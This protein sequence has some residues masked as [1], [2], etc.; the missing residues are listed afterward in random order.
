ML[1][2]LQRL[3]RQPLGLFLALVARVRSVPE[4][5]QREE[6]H[7]EDAEHR[8]TDQHPPQPLNVGLGVAVEG[9]AN[10]VV[11]LEDLSPS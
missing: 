9:N 5:T 11:D 7:E 3:L 2:Q 8:P 10:L 6:G 1:L 4:R